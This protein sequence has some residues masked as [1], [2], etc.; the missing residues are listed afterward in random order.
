M[1]RASLI[2]AALVLAGCATTPVAAN[3]SLAETNQR[4]ASAR[5]NGKEILSLDGTLGRDNAELRTG[6]DRLGGDLNIFRS[7]LNVIRPK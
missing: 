4:I 3:R 5:G 2:F 6:S 7:I 1:T